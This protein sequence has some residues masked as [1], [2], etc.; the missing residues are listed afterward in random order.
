MF[1]CHTFLVRPLQLIKKSDSIYPIVFNLFTI[2]T[3]I[4]SKLLHPIIKNVKRPKHCTKKIIKLK[5]KKLYGNVQGKKENLCLLIC[6]SRS[7][8]LMFDCVTAAVI[9]SVT[10][11]YLFAAFLDYSVYR[12][13]EYGA[14]WLSMHFINNF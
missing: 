4:N 5:I 14:N 13:Y 7:I 1:T 6:F 11:S 2:V 9:I 8:W 12:I 3:L 10:P